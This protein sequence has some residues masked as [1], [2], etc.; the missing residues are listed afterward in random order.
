MGLQMTARVTMGSQDTRASRNQGVV[1]QMYADL[2][3]GDGEAVLSTLSET[4]EWVVAAGLP[5][6]GTY[7][8]REAVLV[9]VFARFDTQW[10]D[11]AVDPAEL[12]AVE[13][14]V[15]ALGHYQGR[16]RETGKAM[17]ARFAH[18]W[19]FEDGVPV[20]FETIADTGIMVAAMS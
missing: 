4:I 7:R 15:I 19:R 5:Y 12:V 10:D 16:G 9:N 3:R 14:V 8:G 11:F 2:S 18:A 20:S 13:D 17:K 1:A 6:G